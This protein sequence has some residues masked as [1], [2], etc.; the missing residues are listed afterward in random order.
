MKNL[1]FTSVFFN[2]KY[3]DLLDLLLESLS[4]WGSFEGDV[5]VMT[6]S[7]FVTHIESLFQKHNIKGGGTFLLDVS[8]MFEASAARLS[9]FEY[10]RIHDYEKVLYLDADVLVTNNLS[11]LFDWPLEKKLYALE[12]DFTT[13]IYHGTYL[14]DHHGVQENKTAFC[15]GVLM[16]PVCEEIKSLFSNIKT[17]IREYTGPELQCLEQP[18]IIFNS[19]KYNMYDNAF[20]TGKVINN[21]QRHSGECVSHF[22]GGPGDSTSKKAKMERMLRQ[23]T[24]YN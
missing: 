7:N 5:M 13:S 3:L 2:S 8:S 19:F 9:I 20:F 21:P 22:C 14:F 24:S 15:A 18:F 10:D 17:H 1:L 6:Q 11:Q 4:R 12:E 16:F 23:L